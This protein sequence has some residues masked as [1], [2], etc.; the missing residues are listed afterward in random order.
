MRRYDSIKEKLSANPILT[1][2][3]VEECGHQFEGFEAFCPACGYWHHVQDGLWCQSRHIS[4]ADVVR[5]GTPKSARRRDS[6]GRAL[7]DSKKSVLYSA[8]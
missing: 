3:P 6:F 7:E 8:I 5:I 1:T 4:S 2:V